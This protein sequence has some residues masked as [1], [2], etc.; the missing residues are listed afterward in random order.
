MSWISR[1]LF[2]ATEAVVPTPEQQK[3]TRDDGQEN[4]PNERRGEEE[5]PGEQPGEQPEEQQPG[6]QQPGE[7]PDE[8]PGESLSEFDNAITGNAAKLIVT[9]GA[10][11]GSNS[12][13]NSNSDTDCDSWETMSDGNSTHSSACASP[14]A[15]PSDSP[16]VSPPDSPRTSP[17]A[18]P[19]SSLPVSPRTSPPASPHSSLPVSPRATT[20]T[21]REDEVHHL[22]VRVEIDERVRSE[23]VK[24]EDEIQSYDEQVLSLENRLAALEISL[25]AQ[26]VGAFAA[27]AEMN[28]S[29]TEQMFNQSLPASP[30]S[31][32][33]TSSDDDDNDSDASPAMSPIQLPPAPPPHSPMP[34]VPL[35]PLLPKLKLSE[36]ERRPLPN[37]RRLDCG[38]EEKQPRGIVEECIVEQSRRARW[39]RQCCSRLCCSISPS[40]H[41]EWACAR[42]GLV[43]QS[44]SEPQRT[45]WE[46]RAQEVPAEF[47]AHTFSVR[48]LFRPLPPLPTNATTT[49]S[50]SDDDDFHV[51]EGSARN[52]AL[53]LNDLGVNSDTDDSMPDLERIS[54]SDSSPPPSDS[55]SDSSSDS[56]SSSS[57]DSSSDSD[58]S[59]SSDD[60][61]CD[62]TS[63]E[64]E[65]GDGDATIDCDASLTDEEERKHDD[66]DDRRSYETSGPDGIRMRDSEYRRPLRPCPRVP[67][68]LRLAAAARRKTTFR[69][70]ASAGGVR[71]GS[72]P[73][74]HDRPRCRQLQQSFGARS[75]ATDA[76]A[77]SRASNSAH[78]AD[79]ARASGVS[80]S[81]RFRTLEQLQLGEVDASNSQPATNEQAKHASEPPVDK[82]PT[83]DWDAL[84]PPIATN[85]CATSSVGGSTGKVN[86]ESFFDQSPILLVEQAPTGECGALEYTGALT[87]AQ[88]NRGDVGYSAALGDTSDES[89]TPPISPARNLFRL[90]IDSITES[91]ESE[92]SESS[93]DK[94][95]STDEDFESEPEEEPDVERDCADRDTT[96]GT[97]HVV[98]LHDRGQS[99]EEMQRAI[100]PLVERAEDEQWPWEFHFQQGFYEAPGGGRAWYQNREGISESFSIRHHSTR[101]SK[102]ARLR[103]RSGHAGG[104]GG[105]TESVPLLCTHAACRR[106]NGVG[107]FRNMRVPCAR[108]ALAN[109]PRSFRQRCEQ[110]RAS[111]A[112]SDW[113]RGDRGDTIVL[114]GFG[115]GACFA[116]DFAY[117]NRH[118]P[119]ES[120]ASSGDA[121]G[122]RD[123]DLPL[124]GVL[125]HSPPF[126]CNYGVRASNTQTESQ[127]PLLIYEESELP[128]LILSSRNNQRVPMNKSS[129]WQRLFPNA[130]LCA[131][132]GRR[133]T[134]HRM[135]WPDAA[136]RAV[137]TL[138]APDSEE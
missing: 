61:S 24:L 46:P 13:S 84:F 99:Y 129:R 98:C 96:F 102:R 64:S 100:A 55:S 67:L 86:D 16:C 76:T 79:S 123:Q 111:L 59:S 136:L 56:D 77:R 33:L 95:Y 22:D 29:V 108:T 21:F 106:L 74:I 25:S 73:P 35:A 89:L 115:E 31:P 104:G 97:T 26:E 62:G 112:S 47:H 122:E 135:H 137:E 93:S 10:S 53:D 138:F 125:A 18:S 7:Q 68:A 91:D 66:D 70:K 117:Q 116:L 40:G 87:G 80:N 110:M 101:K 113:L 36:R 9:K 134:G 120:S 88:G 114:L 133:F 126:P 44:E 52:L 83:I 34:N 81:F 85:G 1:L 107:R 8:H 69:R 127:Q 124:V 48:N 15:S 28:A 128:A 17:P 27:E 65:I 119:L 75:T 5:Q 20:P 109:E 72:R 60:D 49:A 23:I 57:G 71:C 94:D 121:S 118:S 39:C 131:F 51:Y 2:S 6:E 82:I 38:E 41:V 105:G 130:N 43:E 92:E 50:V 3:P 42:C 4:P 12:D 19:H 32:S 45:R 30:C 37:P 103:E 54:E 58:D 78:S 90:L 11:S 63:S 14:L 132:G